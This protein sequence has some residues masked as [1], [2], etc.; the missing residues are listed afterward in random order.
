MRITLTAT[1]CLVTCIVA[2]AGLSLADCTGVA[3]VGFTGLT[4]VTVA[5]G[6]PGRILGAASPPGDRDR[7][8]ILSQ[9]GYIHIKKRGEPVSTKYLFLDLSG[10]VQSAAGGEMGLLGLAFD[11]DYA[12]NGRFYVDYT[13]GPAGGPWFTVVARYTVSAGNPDLANPASEVRIL[14]FS[15]PET[16]HNGGQLLFGPDG[17]LYVATGDG[18][19]GGDFHGTCGNGQ[20][21][22]TLLGKLLRIDVRGID[23]MG[24][25]PDCG[26]VAGMYTVPSGNPFSDGPAGSCDEV[27]D[28]GLRNPWRNSIDPATGDFYI[29]DVGQNCWEEIDWVPGPGGAH[30]YGW[31]VMEGNHCFDP[32]N[33]TNC[34][35]AGATCGS[36]PPCNDP[37]LTDPIVEIDRSNACAVTGGYVYRGC[38]LPWLSGT[39]F[40]GDFCGGWVRSLRMVG[41]S[42]TEA[43]DRTI[44]LGVGTTLRFQLTSFGLDDDGE[45]YVVNQSG[46][47]LR[48]APRF[49]NLEV[50]G[51]GAADL[52]TLGPG[53]WTWENLFRTTMHPVSSYRVYRGLPGGTFT[54]VFTGSLPQWSTGDPAVP[55]AG[56]MNAYIVTAVNASGQMTRSGNPPHTL[57]AAPCP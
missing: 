56:Q 32:A 44:E 27:W 3:P 15:Q 11:P 39:Y 23:P 30:N 25:A 16:N 38:Q 7:I 43:T 47:L 4:A 9:D 18:G 45:I 12:S 17:Y 57:S 22:E 8:F 21:L 40:Y 49:I 48:I 52:F 2:T 1:F 42:V 26:G 46:S 50:S 5:T 33:Q 36:S 41:G 34:F 14:R 6:I 55:P 54:C 20:A 31:R 35:T 37:S 53:A 28:Y 19:G 13:E 51:E 24:T 29:G 10:I